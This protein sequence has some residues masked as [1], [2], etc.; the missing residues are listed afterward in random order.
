MAYRRFAVVNAVHL[1]TKIATTHLQQI[2]HAMQNETE[3]G[4]KRWYVAK[5]SP[6]GHADASWL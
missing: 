1:H 4:A 2:Y 5:G 3:T 6:A